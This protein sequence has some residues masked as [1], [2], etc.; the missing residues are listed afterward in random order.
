MW[1]NKVTDYDVKRAFFYR[2]IGWLG[3]VHHIAQ[4][5]Q[6]RSNQFEKKKKNS[7]WKSEGIENGKNEKL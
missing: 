2:V 4:P 7:K 5:S 1:M 6:S 3:N